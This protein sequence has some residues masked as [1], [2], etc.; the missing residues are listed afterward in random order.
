[1]KLKNNARYYLACTTLLMVGFT[2]ACQHAAITET[3]PTFSVHDELI[4]VPED[5]P[6]KNKLKV[7]EVGTEDYQ[8]KITTSG[9]VKAIS[10]QYAE[11]APPFQGRV[12]KS[13]LKLG[14]KT[15]PETPLFELAAPDF[16]AAQ[17]IFFQEKTQLEQAAR[18]LKRQKDLMNHGVGTQKDLEEA[19]TAY[20]VE[21]KEYENAAAAIRLFK[22]DPAKISLGQPLV[23]RAPIQGEVIENKVV[24]GQFIKEDAVPVAAIANLSEVWIAGKVKEKDIQH[25]HQQDACE[26]EVDALPGKKITGKVYHIQ[27]I[28]DEETRSIEVLI[29]CKNTDH[30]LK[31]GMY[32][33]VKFISAPTPAILIPLKAVLQASSSSFVF[34]ETGAG[35]YQKRKIETGD[36][37]GDKIV[38]RSGLN[39]GDKIVTE[40]G[41]YLLEAK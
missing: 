21:K 16:M 28:L 27:E 29:I 3:E 12:V 5:S 20:E 41:F 11:I 24:L 15:N 34:I 1:M 19:Q 18:T 32:G 25:I 23:V 14:M 31:P 37:S 36:T 40:G 10:T 4:S 7:E 2:P 26:V 13:Y 6:L 38:V 33:S 35:K 8:L 17:K 30:S 9:T 39:K 22:A